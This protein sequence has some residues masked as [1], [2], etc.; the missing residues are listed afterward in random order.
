MSYLTLPNHA[1]VWVYQSNRAFT[2]E[3]TVEIKGKAQLFVQGWASHG[4]AL[5]AA[6][7]I[8]YNRFIVIF[9][10]EQQAAA[11]GCSIDTSVGF[12]RDL[13]SAYSINLLDRMTMA[14]KE[15]D[16]VK[17]AAMNEFEAMIEAGTITGST[18]VFNNLVADKGEFVA[19][20][21]GPLQASWHAR[22]MTQ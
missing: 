15:G 12:I 7:E 20:W 4:A 6:I 2:P 11:S 19:G 16:E 17:T 3:E 14:W 21:E 1:R 18:I 22:L 8:F 9:V 13:Q 5:K 10:D